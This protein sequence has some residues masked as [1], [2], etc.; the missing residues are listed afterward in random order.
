MEWESKKLGQTRERVIYALRPV[1]CDDGKTRMFCKLKV[2]E[3]VKRMNPLSVTSIL[4]WAITHAW[5]V[6]EK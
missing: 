1:R 4:Y 2:K 3:E 5:P 6:G